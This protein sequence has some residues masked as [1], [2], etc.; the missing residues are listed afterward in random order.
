MRYLGLGLDVSLALIRLRKYL[1]AAACLL[2]GFLAQAQPGKPS[3]HHF[4][5]IDQV[6]SATS[7]GHQSVVLAPDSSFHLGPDGLLFEG[8]LL[9]NAHC[10]EGKSGWM[11]HGKARFS[12]DTLVI[13]LFRAERAY[14]HHLEI[15]VWRGEF[16]TAY[17]ILSRQGMSQVTFLPNDQVLVLEKIGFNRGEIVTGFVNFRGSRWEE[18][19]PAKP[20]EAKMDWV[21]SSRVVRGPFKIVIE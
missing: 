5:T 16:M 2:A 9:E 12:L 19:Q 11:I 13:S 18:K 14:I 7:I 17:Q 8:E 4:V 1:I 21:E 15:K 20:W 3:V 6:P 10:R